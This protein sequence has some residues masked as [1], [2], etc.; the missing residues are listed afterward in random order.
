[1]PETVTEDIGA[2][3]SEAELDHV[4]DEVQGT[5]GGTVRAQMA[6]TPASTRSPLNGMMVQDS[7]SPAFDAIRGGQLPLVADTMFADTFEP[8]AQAGA[9]VELPPASVGPLSL[10]I[11]ASKG[12]PSA[13]FEVATRLAEGKGTDQNFKEAAR[14]YQRSASKGFAQAQ[15]R[16]ATLYERGLGM[17][18]DLAR[19]KSWYQRSAEQGN[20]KSMHNLAVLAAGRGGVTPDYTTAANW[21]TQA[22]NHGLADS[23]YNLAVLT[24]SGLGV[25]KDPVQAAMWF[26][27]AARGGDKE[28]IRRRDQMK[29]K[30][31]RNEWSAADHLART[32][33]PMTPDKLANDTHAAGELWK[34]R[35]AGQPDQG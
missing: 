26:I 35:V 28:A 15:Y 22:S 24:E 21:F 12:D 20:V 7:A 3:G 2:N 33:Q 16:L 14:W 10:R 17:K 9:A 23:Q 27:L 29:A 30:M 19:A 6:S 8:Q 11:A 18:A 5:D 34:S 4:P 1:V 32:W 31:D 13:E 25:Q